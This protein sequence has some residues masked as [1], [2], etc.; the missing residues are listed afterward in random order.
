MVLEGGIQDYSSCSFL[1]L[2]DPPKAFLITISP[3]DTCIIN[4]WPDQNIVIR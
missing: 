1:E 3:E 2:Q 4:H